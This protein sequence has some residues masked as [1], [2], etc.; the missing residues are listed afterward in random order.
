MDREAWRNESLI[1][2]ATC[3]YGCGFSER[4]SGRNTQKHQSDPQLH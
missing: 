2:R 3:R 4:P 1:G